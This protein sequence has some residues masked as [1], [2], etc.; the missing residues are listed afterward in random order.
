MCTINSSQV[1]KKEVLMQRNSSVIYK[2]NY[3]PKDCI[4]LYKTVEDSSMSKVFWILTDSFERWI[5]FLMLN[6]A[7]QYHL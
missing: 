3:L 5:E 1:L 6:S 2:N 7:L 4:L